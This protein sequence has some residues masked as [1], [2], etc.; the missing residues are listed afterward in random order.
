[1]SSK[2]PCPSCGIENFESS[3][4]CWQCGKPV[5]MQNR[6]DIRQDTQQATQ[7]SGPPVM[8]QMNAKRPLPLT[9]ML[10]VKWITITLGII[11]LFVKIAHAPQIAS[12]V[13]SSALHS[14]STRPSVPGLPTGTPGSGIPSGFPAGNAAAISHMDSIMINV[15]VGMG[16]FMILVMALEA[17]FVYKTWMGYAWARIV[18]MIIQVFAVLGG[19]I[20]VAWAAS[21]SSMTSMPGMPTGMPMHTGGS[22][23]YLVFG[24]LL[25]NIAFLVI[26]FLPETTQYCRK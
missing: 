15:M 12:M 22:N 7:M 18:S 4:V 26:L 14:M 16:I 1:M 13:S 2:I 20:N 11:G 17:F 6:Q 19:L 10:I 9:I 23:A 24:T 5:R 8:P 25:I 3:V 21:R